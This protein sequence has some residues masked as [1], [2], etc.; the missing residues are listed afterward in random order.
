MTWNF[1]CH[2]TFHMVLIKIRF[3]SRSIFVLTNLAL[4]FQPLARISAFLYRPKFFVTHYSEYN[5]SKL[6][7][8]LMTNVDIEHLYH[9]PDWKKWK[10]FLQKNA[11]FEEDIL[12]KGAITYVT[13]VMCL[14]K[15]NWFHLTINSTLIFQWSHFETKPDL[16]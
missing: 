15:Y 9:F 7:N 4:D 5:Y 10:R 11:R 2:P 8:V 13:N 14:P 16:I 12:R 1:V 3:H 6:D